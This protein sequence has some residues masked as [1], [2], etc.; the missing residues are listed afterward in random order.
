[1][2]KENAKDCMTNTWQGLNKTFEPFLAINKQDSEED[3]H[4]KASTNMTIESIL[5]PAGGFI[6]S[7]RVTCRLRPRQQI[8]TVTIGRRE[9]GILGIRDCLTIREQ[10]FSEFRT[11]FGCR[12]IN[13][14]PI[15]GGRCEQNTHSYN[16]Y[17]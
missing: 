14:Q 12:E 2:Q 6:E 9:V 10:I 17:R 1:M 16:M 13:F 7:H 8:E 3:K 5:K 15:D 11:S 4:S